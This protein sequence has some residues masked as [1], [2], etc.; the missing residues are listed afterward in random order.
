MDTDLDQAIA[1][2]KFIDERWE[3]L[4]ENIGTARLLYCVSNTDC[5]DKTLL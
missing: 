4:S 2:R 5:I 1:N 3:M